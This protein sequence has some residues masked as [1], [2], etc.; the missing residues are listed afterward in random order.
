MDFFTYLTL[1]E[2]I[3]LHEISIAEFGGTRG[4]RSIELVES[5]IMRPQQSFGGVDLYVE[6]WDKA[7]ALAHSISENQ[8]FLD[9]NK[10]TAA[11]SMMVFLE[12]NGY[13]LLVEKMAV[14]NIMMDVA[15]KRIDTPA[16]AA[17]LQQNSRPVP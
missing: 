10:R 12:L 1:E 17:W 2:V 11:L 15:N 4:V 16:L 8:P 3:G 9:G 6:L 13:E 14:Y 7:A 5:A